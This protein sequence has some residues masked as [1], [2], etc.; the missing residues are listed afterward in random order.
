MPSSTSQNIAPVLFQG[1]TKWTEGIPESGFE[2][3][4]E[5]ADNFSKDFSRNMNNSGVLSKRK[6][7]FNMPDAEDKKIFSGM[8]E[9][10]S[11]F[12]HNSG[13]A[14]ASSWSIALFYSSRNSKNCEVH[15]N[16]RSYIFYANQRQI[17]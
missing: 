11:M 5:A 4:M 3:R 10:E 7:D 2:F 9:N 15:A 14:R 17:S 16:N 8:G 13:N 12:K 1:T 6:S